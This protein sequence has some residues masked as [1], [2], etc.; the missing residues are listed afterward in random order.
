MPTTT[1]T[2]P[3]PSPTSPTSVWDIS[4]IVVEIMGHNS[5]SRAALAACATVSHALS[6]PALEVLW[7]TMEGLNPL[8]A[9]LTKSI[10]II[11]GQEPGGW[12]KTFVSASF[13]MCHISRRPSHAPASFVRSSLRLL[14]INNGTGSSTMPR[15]CEN[16]STGGTTSMEYRAG[17]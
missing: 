15:L 4:E 10:E 3:P 2:N 9:I 17:H 16:T 1:Q 13:P 8:F 11:Q 12:K 7:G 5:D 14:T 6:E